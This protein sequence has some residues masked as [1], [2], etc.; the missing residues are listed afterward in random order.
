MTV[1]ACDLP[2]GALLAA[3]VAREG[4]Y[5]DCFEVAVGAE[6]ALPAFV[7]AF[8]TTWLFRLE[9][10]VLSVALRKRI[11]DSDVA[12]LA[13]G[14]AE[15]FAVWTV[16]ARGTGQILLCDITGATRSYLAVTA[17]ADGMTRLIFGSAVLGRNKGKLPLLVR[18]TTP[19]HRF[20]SKALLQLAA[21]RLGRG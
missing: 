2:E 11:R 1:R 19:L 3:Y 20:Y 4:T 9:R 18:V 15:C 17:Y 6:A 8:Y 10:A 13:D 12:A 16:E 21:R 5:T 7:T 14:R